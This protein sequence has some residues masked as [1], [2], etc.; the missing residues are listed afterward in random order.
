[1]IL[2]K[3]ISNENSL[4]FKFFVIW[5]QNVNDG[6]LLGGIHQMTY[7]KVGFSNKITLKW[8]RCVK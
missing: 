8:H 2:I 1:M 4:N 6:F 3:N 7:N 5:D